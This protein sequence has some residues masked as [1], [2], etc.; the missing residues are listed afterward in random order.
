M[1]YLVK[2]LRSIG[3]Q[4]ASSVRHYY[5][6][7]VILGGAFLLASCT[8]LP[9]GLDR[10]R[11]AVFYP[12]LPNEPK[13]QLLT[14]INA[15]LV[16]GK[17]KNHFSEFI[18]GKD[19]VN[20]SRLT[21]PYGVAFY[22]SQVLVVDTRGPGYMILDAND[23]VTKVV[24]GTGPGRMQK[25]INI[26]LDKRGNRFVA[27]TYRNQVLMFDRDDQFVS[28]FGKIDQFKPSDILIVDSEL[29]VSDLEH[30][31]IHVIDV[32]SGVTVRTI[33]ERGS[34]DGELFFPTNMALT[35]KGNIL[36][37]DT[38]NYRLQEFDRSGRFIRAYGEAGNG[39]G[40]F[41]RPKGIAVDKNGLIYAVDSAFENIQLF[42]RHGKLLLFFGK[43]GNDFD[44]INLPADIT[45]SY[46]GVDQFKRF[47]DDRFQVEYLIFVTSQY[48][49]NKITVY[50]F[51]EYL[52][53]I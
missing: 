53:R 46:T 41:A 22:R 1:W 21:K 31:K 48:G 30:H 49:P 51:G 23:K 7:S 28:A 9:T 29:Y 2:A 38:G 32:E 47:A 5:A 6:V 16:Q 26:T 20:E 13:I 37:S 40:Q 4:P 24:N 14:T 43:P 44:N 34:A 33:A 25:P 18:L 11:T 27:D 45:I 42:D 19:E 8:L 10:G 50:G 36:V 12:P 39:L 35:P 17:K 15:S 3:G 52:K